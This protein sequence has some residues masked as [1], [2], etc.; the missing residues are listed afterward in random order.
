[1]NELYAYATDT[2]IYASAVVIYLFVRIISQ[3]VTAVDNPVLAVFWRRLLPLV[4]PA[5]AIPLALHGDIPLADGKGL[6]AQLGT[7]I[8]ISYMAEKVHKILGQT[9]LGD[10]ALIERALSAMLRKPPTQPPT[11]PK[12]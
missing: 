10:D 9:V 11:P 5:I 4:P 2:T 7:G 3:F 12:E 6:V 8:W 1:M